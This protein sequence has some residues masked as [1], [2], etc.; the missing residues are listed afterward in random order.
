M[1]YAH[2]RQDPETGFWGGGIQATFKLL[3]TVHDPAE[4]PVP[5]ADR[6]I[7][8]VLR[9]MEKPT[10]DDL[11]PC[12]EFDAFYDL[13]IAATSAPGYREEEIKKVAAHRIHYILESHR[14]VDG[15]LS[16]YLDRCIPTW[17]KWDMAPAILQGDAFGWG[18]YS[19][20]INICVD[21]LGIANQVP[22][23]G[24]WR[25]R[26]EYDTSAFVVVGKE[27]SQV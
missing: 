12:E 20:G 14:Q 19:Y 9:V 15:G 2:S 13:A 25:Q 7:D 10:Y 1:D 8:S 4:M 27:L 16:S 26:D 11:F 22:W 5:Q 21:I 3:I 23:S 17:L 6:I 18:I 24:K